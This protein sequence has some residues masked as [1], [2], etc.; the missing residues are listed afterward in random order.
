M[1]KTLE[2]KNTNVIQGKYSGERGIDEG[3]LDTTLF[4]E[5]E[6]LILGMTFLT[7]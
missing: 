2:Q 3:R 1:I 7:M 6:E 4:K 5:K